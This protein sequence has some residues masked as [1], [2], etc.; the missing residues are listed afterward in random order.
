MIHCL[1]SGR[2]HHGLRSNG[3]TVGIKAV[4]RRSRSLDRKGLTTR[5]PTPRSSGRATVRWAGAE[6]P[7]ADPTCTAARRPQIAY[8]LA[9]G[10]RRAAHASARGGRSP[11]NASYVRW[12][13]RNTLHAWPTRPVADLYR[14]RDHLRGHMSVRSARRGEAKHRGACKERATHQPQRPQPYSLWA[15]GSPG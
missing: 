3:A 10:G 14:T 13:D 11:L 6:A 1:I 5:G 8:S 7:R 4:E 12:P 15:T 9:G 2:L